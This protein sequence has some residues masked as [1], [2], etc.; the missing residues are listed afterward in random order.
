MTYLLD[1]DTLVHFLRGNRRVVDLMADAGSAD[2]AVSSI[3]LA[4]LYYGAFLSDHASANLEL[5]D[6]LRGMLREI[7]FDRQ[8]A[9]LFGRLKA[10][11]KRQGRRISN[12]DLFFASTA[13]VHGCVL[14]TGNLGHFDRVPALEIEDWS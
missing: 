13:F 10:D 8:A 6:E 4:E 11:L 7:P 12:T 3:S 1:S 2:L 5:V 14:V 9:V